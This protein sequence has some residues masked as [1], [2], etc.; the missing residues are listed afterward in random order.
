MCLTDT[1]KSTVSAW[2]AEGK[3][4][5]DVQR[6]LRDECSL[7]L[8][9][10]DVRFLV[11]DLDIALAQPDAEDVEAADTKVEEPEIVQEQTVDGVTIDVDAII[12]PGTLLSGKVTFSDGTS[13]PWQL[14]GSGQIRLVRDDDETYRPSAEDLQEFQIKLQDVLQ[15]KGY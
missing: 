15:K 1:Q 10:M 5:A 8:T 7:T 2:I 13:L 6:L 9:Y 14:S 4:I 11:D 12:S 3:S